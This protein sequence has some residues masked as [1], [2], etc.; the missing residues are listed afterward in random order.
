LTVLEA[1]DL[2]RDGV[3]KA[4]GQTWADFGAGEG[5][6]TQA[7]IALVGEQGRVIA[8]DRDDVAL[9]ELRRISRDTRAPRVDIID[10]DVRRLHAMP[11]MPGIQLDG[12]LFANVL[13]FIQNPLAVLTQVR[14]YVRPAG[15][16][17]I[18]EY[19]QRAASQWVPFPLPLQ[20]LETI[21]R[22]AGF[23][24]VVETAR[25]KSRYQGELYCA[26]LQL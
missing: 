15:R 26:L 3:G 20:Q 1:T 21:A 2:I 6:F 24:A 8:V 23:A 14:T 18:V 19:E 11:G 12:A 9:R 17:L 13:H 7:L 10:G 4:D 22:A 25:R 16:V 5:T